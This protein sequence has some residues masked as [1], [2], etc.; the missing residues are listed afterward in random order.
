MNRSSRPADNVA[1][2]NHAFVAVEEQFLRLVQLDTALLLDFYHVDVGAQGEAGIV[3]DVDRRQSFHRSLRHLALRRF[4]GATRAILVVEAAFRSTHHV[5]VLHGVVRG[6]LVQVVVV[7][8]HRFVRS[9]LLASLV[10]RRAL[11]RSLF[12]HRL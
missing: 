3:E 6:E 1:Q 2:V 4:A 10:A 9:R 11:V 12:E 7:L 8:A 5:A